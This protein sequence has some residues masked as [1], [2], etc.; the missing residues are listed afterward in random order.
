MIKYNLYDKSLITETSQWVFNCSGSEV[1]N[2]WVGRQQQIRDQDSRE[3]GEK[4]KHIWN[5]E[6]PNKSPSLADK[7]ELNIKGNFKVSILT[8]VMIHRPNKQLVYEGDISFLVT[9]L[10]PS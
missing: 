3:K 1:V 6:N 10:L 9:F 8:A 5:R 2:L 4:P 7:R